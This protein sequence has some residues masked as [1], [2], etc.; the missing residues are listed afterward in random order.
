MLT[1]HPD[2]AFNNSNTPQLIPAIELDTILLRVTDQLYE[3]EFQI[4]SDA[5]VNE[6]VNRIHQ[7]LVQ[8]RFEEYWFISTD[9]LI[10]DL[11]SVFSIIGCSGHSQTECVSEEELQAA[12]KYSLYECHIGHRFPVT[13]DMVLMKEALEKR[14]ICQCTLASVVQKFNS[15]L[16]ERVVYPTVTS[17]LHSIANSIRY[18][19]LQQKPS[20]SVPSSCYP[21][22]E[23]YFNCIT[24]HSRMSSYGAL[25]TENEAESDVYAVNNGWTW[26]NNQDPLNQQLNTRCFVFRDEST[27]YR[28]HTAYLLREVV[29]W[30]DCVKLRYYDGD[31]PTWIL[32]VMEEYIQICA[33]LFDGFRLDNCHNTSIRLLEHLL[34]KAREVKPSL[35]VLAEL[36]TSNENTDVEYIRRVGIDMIVRETARDPHEYSN[37][38]NYSDLLFSAG[39]EDLGSLQGIK[40]IPRYITNTHL[41]VVLYDLTH[42]NQSFR[43]LYGI[44][45]I[46]AVTVMMSLVVAH[47]AS[48]RG[49]DE[50]YICNPSVTETRKY[51]NANRILASLPDYEIERIRNELFETEP[52]SSTLH[53]SGNMHLRLL[54]NHLHQLLSRELFV[55]RY[56]HHYSGSHL[57]SIE[58]RQT[59]SNYSVLNITHTAFTPHSSSIQEIR[60]LGRI[61]GVFVSVLCTTQDGNEEEETKLW[62][63]REELSGVAFTLDIRCDRL[64]DFCTVEE[65]ENETVLH[66]S[67]AFTPGSSVVLLLYNGNIPRS[68]HILKYSECRCWFYS[69][70]V[71]CNVIATTR[72]RLSMLPRHPENAI[73]AI[74]NQI[75]HMSEIHWDDFSY[76]LF[77]SE[78]E[79]RTIDNSGVYVIHEKDNGI[80]HYLDLVTGSYYQHHNHYGMGRFPYAGFYGVIPA[81]HQIIKFNLLNHPLLENIRQGNWLIDYLLQRLTKRPG[82]QWLYL[83]LLDEMNYI[84]QCPRNTRPVKF[85]RLMHH[86]D[87]SSHILHLIC[88]VFVREIGRKL[89]APP[90]NITLCRLAVATLQ[91]TQRL[92]QD[93]I[94]PILAGIPHFTVGIM[95]NW[96]RDTFIAAPGILLAT[97]R[98]QEAKEIIVA[99]GAAAR[100]GLICNLFADGIVP[101]FNSRDAVW[102]WLRV[103][104]CLVISL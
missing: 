97:N 100:H 9:T 34:G 7:A 32:S 50:G 90:D 3:E 46:P 37:T 33:Y 54:M 42:D 26:N 30:S 6:V 14:T 89:G 76:M 96:G 60:V 73:T 28:I 25:V 56:V 101:R 48:T 47:V 83:I 67:A 92:P 39:G 58:R 63:E 1:D 18:R 20:S 104:S 59:G 75:Q 16:R 10:H 87:Q 95:R 41:P 61:E 79:Q 43:K 84:K 82:L 80:G 21:L 88:R 29:I 31:K 65:Q 35:V 71:G 4:T 64:H 103:S 15:E 66:F 40:G 44:A 86:L 91:F 77:T 70:F 69:S 2:I 24:R 45:S 53:L 19:F 93:S 102:W 98:L 22:V 23:R 49:Q 27:S 94:P 55:E 13:V 5:K 62:K 74:A 85:C 12:L 38:K 36:F 8:A 78:E 57:I 17:I 72:Q 81:I 51:A 52:S 68:D 11:S 99:Y